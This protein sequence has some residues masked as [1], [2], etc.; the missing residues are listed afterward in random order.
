MTYVISLCIVAWQRIWPENT[1]WR[2]KTNIKQINVY[3]LLFDRSSNSR[4]I[5]SKW[6]IWLRQFVGHFLCN[7]S[8]SLSVYDTDTKMN[9][10]LVLVSCS[11]LSERT[12]HNF[13]LWIIN[14]M[15]RPASYAEVFWLKTKTLN[16]F[17]VLAHL[18]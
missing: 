2:T 10:L 5:N 4:V 14:V 17:V 16:H 13:F 11:L 15:V 9:F 12:G 18:T 7:C 3:S 8:Y 6:I 1:K